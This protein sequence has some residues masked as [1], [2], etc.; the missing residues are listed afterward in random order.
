MSERILKV[1]SP[2]RPWRRCHGLSF[3]HAFLPI[4]SERAFIGISCLEFSVDGLGRNGMA[5]MDECMNGFISVS[6][7]KRGW[8]GSA[9]KLY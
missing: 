3:W 7:K 9:G 6:L 4:S 5:S 8:P 2:V 1:R